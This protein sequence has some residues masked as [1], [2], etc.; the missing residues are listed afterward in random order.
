MLDDPDLEELALRVAELLAPQLVQPLGAG[1][2]DVD[3]VAALLKVSRDW[4]YEHQ[5]ELGAVRLG[6]GARPTL[7]FEAAR[8]REYV[9]ARRVDGQ[10]E[11]PRRRGPRRS[12]RAVELLPLRGASG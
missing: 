4:V 1:L 2:V 8:V 6:A 11:A 7:R 12:T 5:A 3:D 9:A 10:Q